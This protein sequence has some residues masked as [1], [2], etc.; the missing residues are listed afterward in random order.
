M[1]K[2]LAN[3]VAPGKPGFNFLSAKGLYRVVI[4][5]GDAEV[6]FPTVEGPLVLEAVDGSYK[7]EIAFADAEAVG[8]HL[9]F[10][11]QVPDRKKKYKCYL[12]DD[13]L[14]IRITAM[15]IGMNDLKYGNE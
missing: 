15:P 14:E 1:A 6:D 10:D 7:R 13:P 2:S 9:I 4:L 12:K 5:Y 11:F 3:P 8:D